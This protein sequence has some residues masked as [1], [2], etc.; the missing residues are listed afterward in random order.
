M[1]GYFFHDLHGPD[2]VIDADGAADFGRDGT[3][4]YIQIEAK[5]FRLEAVSGSSRGSRRTVSMQISAGLYR[6][7][8][9]VQG[10][11]ANRWNAFL[12]RGQ[13]KGADAVTILG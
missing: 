4:S 9:G 8:D 13:Q 1:P 2:L 11:V 7:G 6:N 12:K 5:D 3:A 10:K